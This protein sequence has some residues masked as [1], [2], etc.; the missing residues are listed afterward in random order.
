MW[1]DLVS[2]RY[3]FFLISGL[4]IIPGLISLVLPG[5]LRPGIDFSSGSVLIFHFD[6][7]D[8]GQTNVRAVFADLGHPEAIVQRSGD[9]AYIVRTAVLA[10]A[11]RD[12][13]GAVAS[14]SEA[15]QLQQAL[16]ERLGPLTIQGVSQVSPL[17]AA[18]IVRNAFLA[19][20]AA[21]A[22][23]LLYLAWA[24][25]RVRS[26]WRYG[27]C[28]VFSLAHDVLAVVGIFSILGRIFAI[29]LD[30]L[31]IVAI[32]TIIGFSVHNAIVVFDRVRE[33]SDRY[34]GLPFEDI[35]NH[36]LM[37]TLGRSLATSLTVILALFTLWLFGGVTIRNFVL[38]LLIGVAA[39]T[40]S[41]IFNAT[42]LLVVW[43]NGELKRLVGR[44][45]PLGSEQQAPSKVRVAH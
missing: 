15:D 33:N 31:F 32:L 10:D 14:P 13:S 5:G 30:S 34:L 22:G 24:F 6:G 43:E 7:N 16:A 19:V 26:P 37:Q 25:R 2:K 27:V 17:I 39:G 35:V 4:V 45:V 36:S 3:W 12:D 40:Y 44:I 38:A 9:S 23:I 8:P 21:C 29:E 28:A 42:M 11:V 18:E 1:F 41:S 20:I